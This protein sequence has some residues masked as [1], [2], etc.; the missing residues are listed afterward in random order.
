MIRFVS[1]SYK[2]RMAKKYCVYVLALCLLQALDLAAQSPKDN[3]IDSVFQRMSTSDKI[4]Q[5]FMIR[6]ASNLPESS[7]NDIENKIRNTGLGGVVFTHDLTPKQGDIIN[8]FQSASKIPLI[9]G[10]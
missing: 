9:I 2:P 3:W 7:L 4:G 5:L 6:M 8:R 1:Y 10:I